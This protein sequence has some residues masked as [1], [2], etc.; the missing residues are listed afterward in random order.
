MD[1]QRTHFAK[2][3]MDDATAALLGSSGGETGVRLPELQSFRAS[4]LMCQP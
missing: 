2:T 3:D 1:W 4:M